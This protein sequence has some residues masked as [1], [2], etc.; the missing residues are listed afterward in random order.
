[1]AVLCQSETEGTH[2]VGYVEIGQGEVLESVRLNSCRCSPLTLS[3]ITED[4][5]V[6]FQLQLNKVNL[7]SP[8]LKFSAGFSVSELPYQEVSSLD[9]GD[10][11]ENTSEPAWTLLNYY[12]SDQ[13]LPL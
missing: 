7:D 6:A 2:L 5:N 8:S 10:M 4:C 11:P 1:V 13:Q 9:L 3:T 12:L